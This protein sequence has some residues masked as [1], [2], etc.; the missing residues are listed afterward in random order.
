MVKRCGEP[1]PEASEVVRP[2]IK[3]GEGRKEVFALDPL[4]R[5]PGLRL[6]KSGAGENGCTRRPDTS[7]LPDSESVPCMP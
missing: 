3:R 2:V 6:T 4:W 5:A 7:V 1:D